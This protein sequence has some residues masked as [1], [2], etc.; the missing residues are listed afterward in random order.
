ML[1]LD[2]YILGNIILFYV[3]FLLEGTLMLFNLYL[4]SIR[5]LHYSESVDSEAGF[6]LKIRALWIQAH[7][8]FIGLGTCNESNEIL[9][10]K[11][12]TT[13]NRDGLVE[14]LIIELYA[15]SACAK[16]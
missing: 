6:F 13:E 1:W 8:L 9:G 7:L 5:G 12:Y 3:S 14:R 11:Q 10:G 15:N 4:R 2:H 16:A